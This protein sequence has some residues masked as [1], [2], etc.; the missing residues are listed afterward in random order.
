M[1]IKDYLTLFTHGSCW[2][3]KLNRN[4]LDK[5]NSKIDRLKSLRKSKMRDLKT[6]R[7]K[8]IRKRSISKLE[9]KKEWLT[10]EFHWKAIRRLL[11]DYDVIFCGD[12]KSHDIVKHK[13]HSK[14]NRDMM[15]MRF[16]KFKQRLSYKTIE[17][18]KMMFLV[19]EPYT[20]QGC[21]FCGNLYKPSGKEYVCK[22]CQ[23]IIGR[24]HNSGKNMAMKGII[25][26]GFY[27]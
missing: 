19:P 13:N 25:E 23:K 18:G 26:N 21:S 3:Y 5:Y 15:D 11:T 27:C 17:R 20:T 7:K 1:G 9:R 8:R 22:P 14:L 2:E 10:D 16:Y 6:G 12:I 24:D 4:T